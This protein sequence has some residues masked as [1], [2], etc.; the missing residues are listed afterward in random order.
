MSDVQ[1]LQSLAAPTKLDLFCCSSISGAGFACISSLTSLQ[2]LIVAN[3]VIN[4]EGAG[5][6]RSLTVLTKL[7]LRRCRSISGAGFACLSSLTSLQE[8]DV[9]YTDINGEGLEGL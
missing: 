7:D 8:L 5:L 4:D 6:S 9:R 1:P 2:E 3:N